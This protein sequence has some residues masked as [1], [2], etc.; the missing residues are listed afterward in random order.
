M[1]GDVDL[2]S[3]RWYLGG[4]QGSPTADIRRGYVSKILM[5]RS[6]F[7]V[8]AL[9][10]C[11]SISRSRTSS[12]VNSPGNQDA[13]VAPECYDD[14]TIKY[15]R[16]VKLSPFVARARCDS[17]AESILLTN[18]PNLVILNAE[19]RYHDYIPNRRVSLYK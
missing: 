13:I 10:A 1:A 17:Q 8:P 11:R 5:F 2:Q 18:V 19:A 15:P 9:P 4:V 16:K 7:R 6:H 14:K 12:D 3:S